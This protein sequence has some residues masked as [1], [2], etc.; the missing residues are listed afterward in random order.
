LCLQFPP[1]WSTKQANHSK[2]SPS[3]G[4]PVSF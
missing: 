2:G 4:G 1:I 3:S